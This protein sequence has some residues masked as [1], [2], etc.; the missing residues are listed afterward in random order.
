MTAVVLVGVMLDRA[1]LTLRTLAV[2]ACGV[3]LV[4]PEAVVH[5]SF[6]MSFAATLALVAAYEKGIGWMTPGRE[7]SRAARIALWGGREIVALA[8]VSMV[9]GLA[10]T[11][12][13]AYHFHRLAPYGVLANL[14]TMPIISAWVMPMGL[15]ALLAAPFGF[16]GFLWVLMGQGIEW[17]I[18]VAL[19]VASLPGAIGRVAAFGV[20]PLLLGTAALVLFC[21]LRSPLRYSSAVLAVAG[22]VLAIRTPQPEILIA[23][24]AEAVA[25]RTEE[26][27][28]A[29]LKV[30]N[31]GFAIREWLAA[32]ADARGP[33]DP[34]LRNGFSCDQTA[35]VAKL[36]GGKLVS[37]VLAPD[38]FAEDCA[39][40]AL[41]VTRRTAPP[42][43]AAKVID[44]TVWPRTGALA[45]RRAGDDLEMVAARPANYR[46][47]WTS[48][49]GEQTTATQSGRR[50]ASRDATPRE[51]DVRADD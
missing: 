44:R 29:I 49:V 43:C 50:P 6:Q 37:V 5:P 4:A 31:D 2:A 51:E 10:T 20:G 15:L 17:M 35:C 48:A 24:G 32:D 39:R 11:L 38:A 33:G 7:T 47:P 36:A 42:F 27:R 40:A 1:A 41:V 3:L 19:W 13:A 30:G 23:P 18:A 16:D 28:L 14:A 22:L 21:L 34:A 25:V 9:A 12:F 45:L 46:R 8:L 26:G